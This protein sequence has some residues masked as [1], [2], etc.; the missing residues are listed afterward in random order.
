VFPGTTGHLDVLRQTEDGDNPEVLVGGVC[1][2]V[3]VEV[4]GVSRLTGRI[5]EWIVAALDLAVSIAADELQHGDRHDTVCD[6]AA[7]DGVLLIRFDHE[8][9]V[10]I[11]QVANPVH[12][13]RCR[14]FAADYLTA[15][16]GGIRPRW[17]C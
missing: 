3:S 17:G 11:R 8:A 16:V 7:D 15:V 1:D 14:V 9:A 2:A 10:V 12:G 6:R 13:N 4:A 5:A